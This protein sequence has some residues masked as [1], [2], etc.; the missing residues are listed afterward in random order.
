MRRTRIRLLLAV[1]LALAV[2]AGSAVATSATAGLW[3][4]SGGQGAGSAR[5]LLSGLE[6]Q[7]LDGRGNNR[8]H[9]RWGLANTPYTRVATPNYT[10]GRSAPSG[11]P[12]ARYVS[13]RIFNDTNQ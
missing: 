3:R 12:P 6:V 9:G 7:S 13:N 2:V 11:G 8:A 5:D 1:P 4:R 10:D